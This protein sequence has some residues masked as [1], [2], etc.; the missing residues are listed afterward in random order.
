MDLTSNLGDKINS[1]RSTFLFYL[2]IFKIKSVKKKCRLNESESFQ[3]I[4]LFEK[5]AN[6][7][8]CS[9]DLDCSL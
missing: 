7:T 3:G 8:A 4:N 6:L 1:M 9:K 2:L 5:W